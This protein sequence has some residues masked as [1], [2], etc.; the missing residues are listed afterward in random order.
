MFIVLE[1][2][3]GAG[4]GQQRNE[5]LLKLG[6]DKSKKITSVEFPDHFGFLYK[7]LI[8]PVLLQKINTSKS[9]LFLAFALDQLLYTE[10]IRQSLGSKEYYFICDGYFTTNIAYQCLV[11]NNF[12][13]ETVLS[14]AKN[15]EIIEPDITVFL[16]VEPEIC[17][18]RKQNESGH[19]EGL[20]I[21]E[22]SLAKQKK[23]QKIYLN[24]IKD[25]IFCPWVLVDGNGIIS[26]VSDLVYTTL[27]NNKFI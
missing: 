3:D 6:K 18:K 5:L 10:K 26:E 23:L 22:R 25:K 20:D 1:G 2:I 16:D 21:Y 15:F 7:E 19:P 12:K 11:N 14:F 9:V 13:L 8:K 24:M 17:L 4:K 27:K